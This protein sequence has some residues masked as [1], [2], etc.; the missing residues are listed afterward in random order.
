MIGYRKIDNSS[1]SLLTE[2]K[3]TYIDSF[4]EDE[5]RELVSL[6]KL[7][8]NEPGF[9][10]YALFNHD[11][12]IGFITEWTFDTFIFFEHF[13]I[14]TNVRNGGFGGAAMKQFMERTSKPIVLEIEVPVDE[15][16]IRRVGFY[17]R[18][19]FVLDHHGYE[20]PPYKKDGQWIPMRLMSYGGINLTEC[21]NEVKKSLY[22]DIY[23]I[24]A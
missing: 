20:Q 22:R 5:R 3:K 21:F 19:G 15:M 16:S 11:E 6:D 23:N 10:V 12:Y 1:D 2:V 17:E 9:N 7:L 13:A 18:L 14:D 8:D 4:P 24:E